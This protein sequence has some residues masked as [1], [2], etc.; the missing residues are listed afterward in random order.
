MTTLISVLLFALVW[1]YYSKLYKFLR[2]YSSTPP[3]Y[4]ERK[5]WD[6]G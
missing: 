4:Y 1:D 6:Y 5:D 3:K 2:G